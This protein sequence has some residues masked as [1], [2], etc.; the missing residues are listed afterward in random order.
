LKINH[1]LAPQRGIDDDPLQVVVR[2]KA[3]AQRFARFCAAI[4][5]AGTLQA[6][7]QVR[8]TLSQVG[9]KALELLFAF[10]DIGIDLWLMG[11]VEGNRPEDLFQTQRRKFWRVVSGE[12]PL[13]KGRRSSPVRTRVPAT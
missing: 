4:F 10:P 6:R 7:V 1:G 2:L 5:L 12:S 11:K 3:N 13:L 8:P 9:H